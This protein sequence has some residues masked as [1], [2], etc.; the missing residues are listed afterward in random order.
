MARPK[1]R[2]ALLVILLLRSSSPTRLAWAPKQRNVSTRLVSSSY[3]LNDRG[4]IWFG[5]SIVPRPMSEN[6]P[7]STICSASMAPV[8]VN[9]GGNASAEEAD[10]GTDDAAVKV[11][12]LKDAELG[13]G[14]EGPQSYSGAEFGTLFKSWCKA[15]K[16][17]I[18]ASGQKPKDFMQAAKAFLPALKEHY[19]NME[20]YHPKSYNAETFILGFW[21]D[22]ANEVGS[23]KFIFFVPALKRIKY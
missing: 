9:T 1:L 2:Y 18:E 20:V 16:E 3:L 6:T 12:D 17:K 23:P 13:F 21:D 5:N 15:V 22:E 8:D 14:Y 4:M 10:E 11:C 7:P 19:S